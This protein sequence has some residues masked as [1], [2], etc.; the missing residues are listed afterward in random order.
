[1]FS[2]L[3]LPPQATLESWAVPVQAFRAEVA[4]RLQAVAVFVHLE[5]NMRTLPHFEQPIPDDWEQLVR[6]TMEKLDAPVPSA[7][8]LYTRGSQRVCF[9][10]IPANPT[11]SIVQSHD[12]LTRLT[13][14][15]T[16]ALPRIARIFVVYE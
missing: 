4:R 14:E 7:V 9:V 6:Q 13:Q 3:E 11:L 2:D 1:M 10:C 8:H 5:P 12:V 15:L 16:A